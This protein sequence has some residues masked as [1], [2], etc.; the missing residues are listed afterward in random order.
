MRIVA[1]RVA[2]GSVTWDEA[3]E[4]QVATIGPGFVLLVGAG[5]DDDESTVRRL[6]DKVI[7]LRV[8]ADQAGKMNLSLEDV[9]ASALI[10]SQFTL[11]ADMS[12]GRRPSLLKAGD[13]KRAEELYLAF[14]E[15][16]RERGIETQTGS[17]GADMRVSIENDGPVTLV[18]SSDDWQTRV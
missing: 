10:V 13:P 2:S 8:F 3:G 7:D 11:F 16:F 6:A 5:S 9:N 17:F 14:A 12:R 18:L 15:R 4:Q 1:Q